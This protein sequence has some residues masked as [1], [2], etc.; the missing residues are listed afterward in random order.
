[1]TKIVL[2]T[3]IGYCWVEQDIEFLECSLDPLVFVQ[4][5]LGLCREVCKK[6]VLEIAYFLIP[7]EGLESIWC[8]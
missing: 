7:S 6:V 4:L 3:L 8:Y 1:M 2:V 5:H